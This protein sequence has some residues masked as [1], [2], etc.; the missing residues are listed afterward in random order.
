MYHNRYTQAVSKIKAPEGAVEK[1]LKTAESFEKKEKV[2]HMKKWIKSAVAASVAVAVT[3]GAII[4]FNLLGSKANSF[5]MTVNAAEITKD[6]PISVGIGEGGMSIATKDDG[7]EYYIDLPLS[8]KGE[9][10]KSVTYSVDKDAIAVHCRKD[11]N[12]VIDGDVVSESIDTLFDQ[13]HIADDMKVLET[14]MENE[15]QSVVETNSLEEKLLNSYV[16]KK[17]S[18]IT[19]AYDNQNPDGCAI[20]I[21]GKRTN[22]PVPDDESLEAKANRL[23]T[24]IGNTLY[25]TVIFDDGTEQKQ[26]IQ[27]GATVTNFGT[28]HSESFNQLTEEEK[29]LKDYTD[30]FVTYSIT[31]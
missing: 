10:I 28:A 31:E 5:V 6:N 4:G 13:T 15:G 29:A 8:V 2:I 30:V 12:P 22:E 18:S 9:N 1:M 21:V 23:D 3:A 11:N 20:G 27:I 14:A 25:C 26:S 16:G 7:M 24:I 17:Y 19:L